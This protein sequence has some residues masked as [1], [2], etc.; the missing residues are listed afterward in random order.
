MAVSTGFQNIEE[1]GLP[2]MQDVFGPIL[3]RTVQLTL[4][5]VKEAGKDDLMAAF[6]EPP[7]VVEA[8][9]EGA[10]EGVQ[11]FLFSQRLAAAI[12]DLMVMGDGTAP[13][14]EEE[15]LDGV[16]EATNQ[17]VGALST[18]WSEKLPTEIRPAG[19]KARLLNWEEA[20]LPFDDLVR[21]DY[22]LNVEDWGEDHFSKLVPARLMEILAPVAEVVA[23]AS[24]GAAP[25]AAPG[26]GGPMEPAEAGETTVK[27]AE[28]A[29]FDV[30]AGGIETHPEAPK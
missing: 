11:Y 1:A 28:F 25:G 6:P 3:N 9:V 5:G 14:S 29:A 21:V 30:G 24:A 2:I 16:S 8:P 10:A 17:I 19:A 27:P 13:F 23:A 12:T 18:F 26:I 20:D 15:S 4:T 22:T 7:V